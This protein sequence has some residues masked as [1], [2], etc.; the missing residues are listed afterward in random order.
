[1]YPARRFALPDEKTICS[2]C[3]KSE[4]QVAKLIQ[5]PGVSICDECVGLCVEL[6]G[7]ELGG[8][9]DRMGPA[10]APRR[11]IYVLQRPSP[12]KVAV[13]DRLVWLAAG[14][15]ALALCQRLMRHVR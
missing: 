2:F 10:P 7:E 15:A 11:P 8:T 6:I 4:W 13:P 3:G 1:M 14:G 12:P 5:G 9:W